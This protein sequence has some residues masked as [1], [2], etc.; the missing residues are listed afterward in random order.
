[1]KKKYA[2][3]LYATV[4]E[5]TGDIQY[6]TVGGDNESMYQAYIMCPALVLSTD[7]LDAWLDS[8]NG[9]TPSWFYK[10]VGG[11]VHTLKDMAKLLELVK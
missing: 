8:H 1:M 5:S 3:T 2:L 4:P 10:T 9:Q 7:A 11:P 6:F